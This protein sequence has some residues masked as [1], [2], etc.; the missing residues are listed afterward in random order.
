MDEKLYYCDECGSSPLKKIDLYKKEF[1]PDCHGQTGEMDE[2]D[3]K[4]MEN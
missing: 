4:S 3:I 2:D 1:C